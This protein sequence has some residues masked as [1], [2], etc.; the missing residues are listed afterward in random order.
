[1]KTVIIK[2]KQ[3]YTDLLIVRAI[4]NCQAFRFHIDTSFP[5]TL[6][7]PEPI[8]ENILVKI[9]N[10]GKVQASGRMINIHLIKNDGQICIHRGLL[11]LYHLF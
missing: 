9:V 8:N 3:Q 6:N 2:W 1:M 10:D 4:K 5:I 7:L 11:Y